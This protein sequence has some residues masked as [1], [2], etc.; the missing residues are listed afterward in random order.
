MIL[1]RPL[2]RSSPCLPIL[3]PGLDPLGPSVDQPTGVRLVQQDATDGDSVP[4]STLQC[5][6]TVRVQF[7]ADTVEATSLSIAGEDAANDLSLEHLDL[8]LSSDG[9]VGVAVAATTVRL[10]DAS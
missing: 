2:D 1:D 6:D 5:G 10:W 9:V 7:A 8:A 4:A 3:A